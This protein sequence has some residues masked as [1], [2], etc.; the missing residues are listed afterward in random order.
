MAVAVGGMDDWAKLRSAFPSESDRKINS[1]DRAE[2]LAL[3]FSASGRSGVRRLSFLILVVHLPSAVA[4]LVQ[5]RSQ[6]VSPDYG[7]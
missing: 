2:L 4:S 6:R 7:I 5:T 3:L 1:Q